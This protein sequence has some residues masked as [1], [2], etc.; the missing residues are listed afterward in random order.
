MKKILIFIVLTV[1]GLYAGTAAAGDWFCP[2]DYEQ[3]CYY[4][5]S[6][7]DR[8]KYCNYKYAG[9]YIFVGH[10]V[11][12]IGKCHAPDSYTTEQLKAFCR[13]KFPECTT[14]CFMSNG[15]DQS[16]RDYYSPICSH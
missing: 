15:V 12:S 9:S 11:W 4:R 7:P 13:E 10:F 1:L 6:E 2:A 5:I 16:K 8:Y 3:S 14:D